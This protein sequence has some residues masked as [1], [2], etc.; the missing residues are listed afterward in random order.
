MQCTLLYFGSAIFSFFAAAAWPLGLFALGLLFRKPLTDA[1]SRLTKINREGAGSTSRRRHFQHRP[2]VRPRCHARRIQTYNFSSM[3]VG[4][5]SLANCEQPSPRS[6][7][8]K[9]RGR[10]LWV[11]Y[12]SCAGPW[13]GY[14]TTLLEAS[15]PSWN[16]CELM[17]PRLS[18]AR[19]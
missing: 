2:T 19:G 14:I 6:R 4:K 9:A 7:L 12:I 11:R 3:P 17:A 10:V 8:V 13:T 15:S 5:P 16:S 18:G 1:L